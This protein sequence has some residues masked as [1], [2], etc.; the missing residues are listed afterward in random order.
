M[1]AEIADASLPDHEARDRERWEGDVTEGVNRLHGRV[2]DIDERTGKRTVSLT[3]APALAAKCMVERC[4]DGLTHDVVSLAD[5]QG[6]YPD[7]SKDELLDGLGELEGYGLIESISFIGSPDEY[8]LSQYGYEVLD[9]PIMGWNTED[10]AREIAALVVK[11]RDNIRSADL[12]AELGWPRRRFNPALRLV[13]DFI[14]R[15]RV[16][17]EI[18]PDYVTRYFSPNNAE[19][20]Q[21]RRFASAG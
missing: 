2:N 21:L 11:K 12:E 17:Q 20:A 7:L 1:L 9:E 10:D 14:D 8:R 15:G 18:Q 5:L 3:G 19:L 16:S 6:A 4:P 13:V